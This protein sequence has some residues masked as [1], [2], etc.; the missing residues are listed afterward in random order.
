MLT[1]ISYSRGM[2][3]NFL[4]EEIA[5]YYTCQNKMSWIHASDCDFRGGRDERLQLSFSLTFICPKSLFLFQGQAK[6][7]W[8]QRGCEVQAKSE[9]A[10]INSV[11]EA[12]L[13]SWMNTW[14]KRKWRINAHR[15]H[16]LAYAWTWELVVWAEEQIFC[17]IPSPR[18]QRGGREG[19]NR[20]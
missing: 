7:R 19:H 17:M 2:V 6:L 8:S 18:T 9:C 12:W 1:D 16:L 5:T 14:W 13:D 15:M 11:T 10:Q 4:Q 20:E 3:Y